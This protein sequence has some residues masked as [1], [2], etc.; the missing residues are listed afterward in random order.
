MIARPDP[1]SQIRDILREGSGAMDSVPD[2]GPMDRAN[3]RHS[4]RP[5]TYAERSMAARKIENCPLI[6]VFHCLRPCCVVAQLRN[7]A[8]CGSESPMLRNLSARSFWAR[9]SRI[10]ILSPKRPEAVYS[11][12]IRTKLAIWKAGFHSR[13]WAN[14]PSKSTA[15]I[16]GCELR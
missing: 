16:L 8:T 12:L 9:L 14:G 4:V 11:L 3:R 5:A 15:L 7:L 6:R 1:K 10:E 13:R 2:A